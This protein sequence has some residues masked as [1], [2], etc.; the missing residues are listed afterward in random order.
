[1]SFSMHGGA[2]ADKEIDATLRFKVRE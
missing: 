2:C 1:M